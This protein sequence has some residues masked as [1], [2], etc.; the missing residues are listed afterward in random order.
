MALLETAAGAFVAD[1]VTNVGKG[2]TAERVRG[3]VEKAAGNDG[4]SA[5][6]Q[7][8]QDIKGLL[9]RIADNTGEAGECAGKIEYTVTLMPS[10]M[11]QPVDLKNRAHVSFLVP[12]GFVLLADVPGI[13]PVTRTVTN[14]GWLSID[15]PAGT[16]FGVPDGA[17]AQA[18]LVR[19]DNAA[20]G[21]TF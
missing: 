21:A 18:V 3:L 6:Q 8:L 12:A 4:P 5:E 13:G 9:Q 16:R 19:L 11:L 2:K 14:G 7:L 17:A 1:V 20:L 15:L 10:P